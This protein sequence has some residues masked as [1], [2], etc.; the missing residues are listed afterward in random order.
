MVGEQRLVSSPLVAL[1]TAWATACTVTVA[2]LSAVALAAPEPDEPW[3]AQQ[4]PHIQRDIGRTARD[5]CPRAGTT[6]AC[7]T[8]PPEHTAQG[9]QTLATADNWVDTLPTSILCR[10]LAKHVQGQR[11]IVCQPN[12][13]PK[14]P[15]SVCQASAECSSRGR[16]HNALLQAQPSTAPHRAASVHRPAC[17]GLGQDRSPWVCTVVAARAVAFAT[18]CLRAPACIRGQFRAG[19]AGLADKPLARLLWLR[20]GQLPGQI[21]HSVPAA[22]GM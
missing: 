11:L 19:K 17:S 4:T 13:L 18:A 14:Y 3:P 12:C 8:Q 15:R 21:P 2:M 1:A 5:T 22:A 6:M 7:C 20:P 9:T 10:G 16:R